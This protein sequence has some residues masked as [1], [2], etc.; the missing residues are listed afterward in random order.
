MHTLLTVLF[1]FEVRKRLSHVCKRY[2][3]IFRPFFV[4][5]MLLVFTS[6]HKIIPAVNTIYGIT[7]PLMHVELVA[8]VLPKKWEPC[9]E[10]GGLFRQWSCPHASCPISLSELPGAQN[11][12]F[13]ISTH[14]HVHIGRTYSTHTHSH[15]RNFL[16]GLLLTT[17][18]LWIYVCMCSY[19]RKLHT[20][21]DAANSVLINCETAN[22]GTYSVASEN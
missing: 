6:W 11:V 8:V 18:T 4:G 21:R 3:R 19:D 15:I 17:F 13:K 1:R 5:D 20:Q 9:I 7:W 12:I 2:L 10:N 14:T 16:C 22:L